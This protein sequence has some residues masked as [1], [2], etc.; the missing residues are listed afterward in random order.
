MG[1]VAF[2]LNYPSSTGIK[3]SCVFHEIENFFI[4]ENISVDVMHDIVES[5]ANYLFREL[6]YDLIIVKQKVFSYSIE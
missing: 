6:L 3:E 4:F 2:Q 5:T 1:S